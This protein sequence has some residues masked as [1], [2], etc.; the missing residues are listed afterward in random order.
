MAEEKGSKLAVREESRE[1]D[2]AI[3]RSSE[4]R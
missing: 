3:G 4:R 2:K 1:S